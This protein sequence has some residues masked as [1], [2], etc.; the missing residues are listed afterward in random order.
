MHTEHTLKLLEDTTISLGRAFRSFVKDTCS[1]F[2]TRELQ[3]EADAR[4]RCQLASASVD[5]T[6]SLNTTRRPKNFN[7]QTYKFHSLGDYAATIRRYGTS[8]SYTTEIVSDSNWMVCIT[9]VYLA[10]GRI[11]TSCLQGQLYSYRSQ[12][13]RK[14]ACPNR[15]SSATYPS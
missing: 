12:T 7:L 10:L 13:I 8:D 1:C 9:Q 3:R 4:N 2:A 11:G 14:T 15:A 6:F 5:R